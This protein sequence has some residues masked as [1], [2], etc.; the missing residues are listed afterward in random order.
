MGT[1]RIRLV[2]RRDIRR[3]YWE[4]QLELQAIGKGDVEK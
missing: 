4:R 2:S 3:E 1:G